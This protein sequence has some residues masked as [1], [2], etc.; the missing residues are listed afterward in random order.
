LKGT[1]AELK[2]FA[3]RARATCAELYDDHNGTPSLSFNEDEQFSELVQKGVAMKR[4]ALPVAS[5]EVLLGK[6][7]RKASGVSVRGVE[8]CVNIVG[9]KVFAGGEVKDM[10]S[11]VTPL[12]AACQGGSFEICDALIKANADTSAVDR[13]G[14]TALLVS[15]PCKSWPRLSQTPRTFLRG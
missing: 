10:A 2:S 15:R 7:F 11:G 8:A 13:Q 3:E 5:K 1:E 12:L 6:W 9:A 4:H 14:S